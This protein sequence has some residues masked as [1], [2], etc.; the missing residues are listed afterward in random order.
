VPPSPMLMEYAVANAEAL[1]REAPL[2]EAAERAMRLI[3]LG[4]AIAAG[5]PSR[6]P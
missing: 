2:R 4:A 5:A 6:A 3:V 1:L